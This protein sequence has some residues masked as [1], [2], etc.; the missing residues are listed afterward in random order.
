MNK[1]KVKNNFKTQNKA[2]YNEFAMGFL[3]LFLSNRIL[4]LEFAKVSKIC[5]N[6]SLVH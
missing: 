4:N 3:N 2:Q 6:K 5:E 1:F